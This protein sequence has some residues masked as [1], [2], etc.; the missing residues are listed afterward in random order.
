MAIIKD[1]Y[2]YCDCGCKLCR[3]G[4]EPKDVIVWCRKCKKE[5]EVKK[6]EGKDVHNK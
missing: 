6:N 1:S 3:V 4:E 2:F 5:I